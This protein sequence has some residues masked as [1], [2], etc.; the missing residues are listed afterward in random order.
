MDFILLH[1]H[2]ILPVIF[3]AYLMIPK[4]N[5]NRDTSNDDIKQHE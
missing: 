2:C 3:V 4:K 1:W 5:K